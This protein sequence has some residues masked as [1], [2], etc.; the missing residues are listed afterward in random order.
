MTAGPPP[1]GPAADAVGPEDLRHYLDARST[2]EQT[3]ARVEVLEHS[4]PVETFNRQLDLLK[5]RLVAQPQAFRELFI[6]D[7]MQ[8]VAL[9]FRQPELGD[10]FVRAMWATLLR[11]DDAAKVLMRFVWGLNLGMKRKFVRGLDRCLSER[12]PMFDGLSQDW[13]AGNSIPPYIRDAQEREHDFGLV[14]QGYQG[15]LTLGY[16]TAEVDLFVWLEALRDKQCEEKPCEIGILLAGRKE[17]KGGCPVKIHIPRVLELVGT[18]RFREAMELIESANPLPDVTGRVCPQELQCQGVCIQN[19][20]PIAIGQLEWFLPERE[21]RLHPDAATDRFAGRR[22]PWDVAARPPVAIVGSGPSGLINA[23]LLGA[24]GFPVTV[25]EAFHALGG[26]LRYGIP[27]FR[28]PNDLID[29]VVGKIRLLGGKFVPNFVV[30]RTATLEELR[31]AGFWKIF[32]GSG[33]GLP[34]F[35]NVPGEHLLNVMS[36]NEFLTRVNLMQGQRADYETPLPEI[37]GK[38]VLVIGGGNTAMDAARTARRLGGEVTIVYRRT[39]KEMPARVEE[40][41]HAL[42][43][44]IALSVLRSPAEFLGDPATNFVTGA[45]LDVMELGR[46]DASG[47]RSPVVTGA[48]ETVVADLVIMALG[49]AANPIIKDSEPRLHTSKWGTID[50]D[51]DGSQETTLPGVYTG[52]D[53]ARGGSTAI[54]A[55]GDGQAAAREI[56]GAIDLEPAVVREMVARAREYSDVAAT[57]QR[58]LHKAE[59]SD[60]IDEFVVHSPLVAHAAQAGQFVRVLPWEHGELIPLTL[61]DW[62][63]DAGTICLVVQ[64]VGTSSIEINRMAVGDSFAGIAGPLGRP[65]EIHRYEPG[66]TV[67]LTAGG[68]GLPPVYPIMREHLRAGNHVTLV[69]GFRSRDLMFWTGPDER[70]GRLQAE[71]GDLLDVVVTT[72]DGSYGVPGFVTGPL[73][74]LL[75]ANRQ[76]EGRRVAEVVTI[77]PPLMMRAVSDLCR[78]FG[79]PCVAS[80]NSIMVDATGMCGACMV[81]V[82]VD[83]KM[84]RKHACIDGPEIDAA[85]IDWDKFLPRFG[86]FRSQE[87][88]SRAQHGL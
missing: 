32:V 18:G 61:A 10:D 57:S 36:A 8:A 28:L 44:E 65:S 58:I 13:P 55:A 25:F 46:P 47:R 68:L 41:H 71:F 70:V 20:M 29:D 73:E 72:N 42:E 64:G 85:I 19:K 26:V 40:L 4:E 12:Y 17:P 2:L 9:E 7:G 69:T 50:L 76:G 23:Y 21:K 49:N 14:N 15:Y 6:A 27:E 16:T 43:E 1:G 54:M 87:Q 59:L 37:E 39:Q 88:R 75:E 83:G 53:A 38:Q 22:D 79:T 81:P 34:R 33:A 66:T 80:L 35:M 51:H 56:I 45:V 86:Q 67:V 63:A 78:R 11:G 24:E 84:V 82:V 62:D 52:G 77:G 31:A 3:R 30:G 5:R 48:Q 74:Q 60:G